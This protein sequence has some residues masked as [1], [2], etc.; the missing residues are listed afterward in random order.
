MTGEPAAPGVTGTPGTPGAPGGRD[1]RS[2]IVIGTGAL[3]IYYGGLLHRAGGRVMFLSMHGEAR[4]ISQRGT[5]GVPP[6]SRSFTI[7]SPAGDNTIDNPRFVSLGE[8]IT[9]CDVAIIC[10][11]TTQNHLLPDLL[12][13][14]LRPGGTALF[15]Q[16]GIG[17]EEEALDVLAP[18][19]I[20][21][22]LCYIGVE[23]IAPDRIRHIDGGR[24]VMG[25]LGARAS[26]LPSLFFQ[27]LLDVANDLKRAGISVQP[28]DDILRAQW[29]KL[30]WNIPFNG[31]SVVLDMMPH[32]IVEA[33][34]D[35]TKRRR[36]EET[37]RRSDAGLDESPRRQEGPGS[38]NRQ[39]PEVHSPLYL[40]ETIMREVLAAARATGRT[41]PDSLINQLID[42]TRTLPPFR[43]SMRMDYDRGREMEL[44]TMY[45][46]PIRLAREHG[47]AMPATEKV[48]RLLQDAG[49][50]NEGMGGGV[51]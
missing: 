15:L 11:K 39:F 10:L 51:T 9:P 47:V 12:P 44:K 8:S 6:G 27:R 30:L 20:L 29:Q 23:R 43:T 35:E 26:R 2:Y 21:I 13:R 4:A 46:N 1:R 17:V 5:P 33:R 19:Q 48:W 3:G 50:R 45:E 7:E 34:D 32:E 31:L 49:E 18:E 36:D 16:N 22:G 37:T 40:V 14:I 41:L 28:T 38:Y 25:E 42:Y 24:I